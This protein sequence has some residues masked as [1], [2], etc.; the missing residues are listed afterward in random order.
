MVMRGCR[1]NKKHIILLAV[2]ENCYGVVSSSSSQSQEPA[3]TPV[4]AT[5]DEKK[6]SLCGCTA[7]KAV[8]LDGASHGHARLQHSTQ[9]ASA[10]SK[11]IH[12]PSFI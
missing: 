5:A 6:A 2:Y 12:I 1:Q 3:G 9:Q 8:Q 10:K 11:P 4:Q 7:G